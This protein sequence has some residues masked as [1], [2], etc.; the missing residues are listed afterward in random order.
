MI[1]LYPGAFKPPHRGHFELVQSLLNGSA[2]ASVYDI[3]DY[4][5]R[6]QEVLNAPQSNYYKIDKVVICIGGKER[7]GIDQILSEKIWNIYSKHLGNVEIRTDEMNP[8]FTAKKYAEANP[9]DVFYAIT[10]IRTEN[11]FVDLKRVT[12]YKNVDNVDGLMVGEVEKGRQLRASDFR[13]TILSGNLDKV[14]DFFPKELD[15]KDI[16]EIMKELKDAIISEQMNAS[17]EGMFESWFITEGSS[18]AQAR[19]S[20]T[21]KSSDRAALVR[22][23]N[24]L[25]GLVTDDIDILIRPPHLIVTPKKLKDPISFDYTPYMGTMIENTLGD[26]NFAPFMASIIEYA[27]DQGMKI[28][29]IPEVKI[30]KDITQ[31]SDFFGRTAYYSPTE[32]EI[33]LY[34][35]DRHP[36][37]IMRSFTHELI[38]HK[39]NLEGKLNNITTQ[40]TNESDRLLELEKE[41]YLEG[42]ILFRNWEDKVKNEYFSK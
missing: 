22:L 36:K 35:L 20:G 18:P 28:Q 33:V 38:H 26:F 31:A 23:H 10:G 4:L 24:Y 6:G 27:L 3:D 17:I 37:D 25:R 13:K 41:A 12:T 9:N 5:E 34:T 39:Q 7:N 15:S 11:D 21:V 14:R 1:A 2:N 16:L 19:P 40:D 30:K 29:P 42:N 32:M 8:M